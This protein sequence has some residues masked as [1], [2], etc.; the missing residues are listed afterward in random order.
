MNIDFFVDHV[1]MVS[2]DWIV[3]EY[4]NMKRFRLKIDWD[5]KDDK[6]VNFKLFERL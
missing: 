2:E 1:Q 4:G 3:M 5:A 6:S